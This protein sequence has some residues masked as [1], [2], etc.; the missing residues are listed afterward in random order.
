[1][2]LSVF[3]VFICLKLVPQVK[4][5]ISIGRAGNFINSDNYYKLQYNLKPL[6]LD[7]CNIMFSLFYNEI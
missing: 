6:V 5:K 7:E 2:D 3:G 1:M 4:N